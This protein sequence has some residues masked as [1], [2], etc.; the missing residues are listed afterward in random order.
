MSDSCTSPS[1]PEICPVCGEDVP[2][3]SLAC[4]G[5]GADHNT[6]W[7][8][9]DDDNAYTLFTPEEDFDYNDY[10]KREFGSSIRPRGVH[11]LWWVTAIIL[12]LA[13]LAYF[14]L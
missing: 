4:P 9:D 1:P 13:L 8:D 11:P 3:R 2:P 7:K 14:L 5:C 12:I 10:I 6:G